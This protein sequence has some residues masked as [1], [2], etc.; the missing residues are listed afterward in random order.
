[1]AL[2]DAGVLTLT[3]SI[4]LREEK[5]VCWVFMLR[6]RPEQQG[7]IVTA[8][9]VRLELPSGMQVRAEEIVIE[10]ERMARSYP[11][12]LWRLT[13]EDEPALRHDA[14]FTFRKNPS[15]A[16]GTSPVGKSAKTT[17]EEP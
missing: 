17:K 9:P 10:D 3:D 6:C 16:C 4:L 1:M 8:G 7:A 11:G 13:C 2:D 15:G 14:A 5:P 12:S